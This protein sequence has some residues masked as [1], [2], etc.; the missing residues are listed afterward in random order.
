MSKK[1][2]LSTAI[3]EVFGKDHFA[4]HIVVG[5]K[6]WCYF[7]SEDKQFRLTKRSW[8]V[9][10][11]TYIRSGVVFY[12]LDD[13]PSVEFHFELGSIMSQQLELYELDPLKELTLPVEIYEFFK[14]NDE[15]T[16]IINFDNSDNE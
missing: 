8:N 14:W 3:C 11:I 5:A 15:R 2:V 9:I 13:N 7:G 6:F 4:E 1:K 12:T 16:K 10:T